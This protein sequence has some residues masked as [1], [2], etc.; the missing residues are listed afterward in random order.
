MTEVVD[1]KMAKMELWRDTM[2]DLMG[3]KLPVTTLTPY[4]PLH[5]IV[6][7]ANGNLQRLLSAM[8]WA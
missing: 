3:G 7:T 1:R 2:G 5:R 6:L 4:D 8:R